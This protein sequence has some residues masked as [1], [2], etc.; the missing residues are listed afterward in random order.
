MDLA[1]HIDHTLL[2]TDAQR[3]DVAKLI[4]EAKTYHFASVC[5]SPIWVSYVSDALRGSGVNYTHKRPLRGHCAP[6]LQKPSQSVC[7]C[8]LTSWGFCNKFHLLYLLAT[9]VHASRMA[10]NAC[11]F[12]DFPLL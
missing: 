11:V 6:P 7:A 10:Q 4:E 1:K 9:S 3:A 12:N 8:G 2:R 5:V